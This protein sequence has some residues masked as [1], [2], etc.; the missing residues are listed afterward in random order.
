M[1]PL[2]PA[3]TYS[4]ASS[5]RLSTVTIP[6]SAGTLR[7]RHHFHRH[8]HSAP[9]PFDAESIT[10]DERS[11]TEQMTPPES[12]T[13]CDSLGPRCSLNTTPPLTPYYSSPSDDTTLGDAAEMALVPIS[14]LA[15]TTGPALALHLHRT[16]NS[17]LACQESMWEELKDYVRNHGEQLMDLGWDEKELTG[18]R[19]R[20]RFEKL[21]ERYSGYVSL[22]LTK[23]IELFSRA[24]NPL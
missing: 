21:I 14:A 11:L 6:E 20:Q 23:I 22:R 4:L 10:D 18:Y 16:C 8:S 17:V 24:G 13:E 2:P 12:T 15:N 19:L 5:R 7:S 9:S 3:P 1:P